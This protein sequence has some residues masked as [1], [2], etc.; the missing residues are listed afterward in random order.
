MSNL[1]PACQAARRA[2]AETGKTQQVRRPGPDGAGGTEAV[3]TVS[4][5]G[6]EALFVWC[7]QGGGLR[8]PQ[9]RTVRKWTRAMWGIIVPFGEWE[10]AGPSSW[11][12]TCEEPPAPDKQTP[13]PPP[14][15]GKEGGGA[16]P[17]G[18]SGKTG[19]DES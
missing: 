6:G 14:G 8:W 3:I 19:G 7:T 16:P 2:L 4:L 17:G 12:V 5:T 15:G 10:R 11:R 9:R 1:R 13:N 18:F